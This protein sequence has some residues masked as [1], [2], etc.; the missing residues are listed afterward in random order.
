M[1][2]SKWSCTKKKKHDKEME[3]RRM[4]GNAKVETMKKGREKQGKS[5]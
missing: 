2:V 4:A 3:R 5:R 1:Y